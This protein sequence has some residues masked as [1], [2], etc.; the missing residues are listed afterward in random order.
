[1]ESKICPDKFY[2][3]NDSSRINCTKLCFIKGYIPCKH[4]KDY[5][6]C[7]NHKPS[8]KRKRL[9]KRKNILNHHYIC[10]IVRLVL[11]ITRYRSDY[12]DIDYQYKKTPDLL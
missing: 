8:N 10:L 11:L 12:Q 5:E 6:I 2:I 4:Y 7:G 9:K 3:C 1:M